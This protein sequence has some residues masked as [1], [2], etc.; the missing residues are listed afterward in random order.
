MISYTK[1][2]ELNICLQQN[3]SRV[4]RMLCEIISQVSSREKSEASLVKDTKKSPTQK[5]APRKKKV[6]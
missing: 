5:R 1:N 6:Q 2:D 4:N 3:L